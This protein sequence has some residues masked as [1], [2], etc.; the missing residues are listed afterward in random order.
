[1]SATCSASRCCLGP[2]S[3]RW[4]FKKTHDASGW[5]LGCAQ[6]QH[7]LVAGPLASEL[8]D[9]TPSHLRQAQHLLLMRILPI[10]TRHL[11]LVRTANAQAGALAA[12]MTA[13]MACG[14]TCCPWSPASAPDDT[15]AAHAKPRACCWYGQ[16]VRTQHLLVIR[17]ATE[18]PGA[19]C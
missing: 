4:C 7:H 18:E 5:K 9:P 17:T 3:R 2:K 8:G 11:L 19:S 10:R 6:S 13:G 16:P 15:N 14:C 12:D 1:M